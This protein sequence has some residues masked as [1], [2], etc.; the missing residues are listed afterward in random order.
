MS[1]RIATDSASDLTSEE[2]EELGIEVVP[3]KIRFGDQE[4]V[5]RDELSVSEF[6]KR[7][8]E[9]DDLPGTAAPSPGAFDTAFR[10]LAADGASTVVCINISSGVSAT[11]EAAQ[12]A[13]KGLEGEIDVRVLDSRALTGGQA[14]ICIQAAN[15]AR[16]G[17]SA[18]DVV[19]LTGDLARR[20]HMLGALDTLEN[21]MKGGRIGRARGMA[22]SVLSIKPVIDFSSG[23]V[24]EAAKP[25]TRKR[26]LLWLRDHV[27]SFGKVESLQI[28]HGEAPDVEEMLDL[29]AEDHDRDAIEV[30]LLGPV[31]GTHAG[32]RI[33]GI[34]FVEG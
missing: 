10:K 3:L 21:L 4:F 34:S 19:A 30:R 16:G 2:V 13:A 33:M 14:N 5:D 31:V 23:E 18:D 1:V 24:E 25:R 7:M 6:Y 28:C 26:A 32:S 20:T 17:A 8:A 12:Q 9:T 27:R 11:I 15:A 22:G 29:L